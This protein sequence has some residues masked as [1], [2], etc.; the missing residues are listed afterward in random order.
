MIIAVVAAACQ[1]CPDCPKCPGEGADAGP[2][3]SGQADAG[4]VQTDAGVAAAGFGGEPQAVTSYDL[5]GRAGFDKV[6]IWERPDMES[7]RLGYM[8]RGQRTM[9]GDPRYA[10]ESCPQGWFAL[11][12]GGFVCQGRGMLV[13]TKPRYIHRP[14]P[15]PRVD[16][17]DPY[18][19]G[20]IRHDWTPLYKR[21]PT[22]EEIW[23]PPR[24]EDEAGGESDAGS[25]LAGQVRPP[26]DPKVEPGEEP[27]PPPE[28]AGEEEPQIPCADYRKHAK[29][30]YRAVRDF[31]SRG[32]WVAVSNRLRDDATAQYYYETIRGEYVPGGSVHLVRPPTYRGYEVLGET[33]LPAAIVSSR[34]AAFFQLRNGKFR[35]VGPADRLSVYR[36]FEESE[37]AGT[38]YYRI[39]G[40]RWLK[41]SQVEHFGIRPLPEGV[42]ENEKWIF[43]DLARQ[44]LEAYDGTTPVY[45]TLVSTGLAESEETV[46]PTG[47]FRINFKHVTDDMT[48]SVGDDEEVYSV[49]DVPWVQYLHM[50]VA[51]HASFWHSRYGTPKSHGCIN[52]SPADARFLFDWSDPP[53][54]SGWHAV[55]AVGGGPKT[56]VIIEGK[57]PK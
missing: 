2:R 17:L 46:T 40:D 34:N 4:L 38:K 36:V 39:E 32:F 11:P 12:G 8:R 55:A 54:P 18:P 20:F 33:P 6:N 44:T 42:G 13:G 48:G 19:H 43:I 10:S 5:H 26:C 56:T 31:L 45:V 51:L 3:A 25:P 24:V 14:P 9:L 28:A 22:A 53:L 23:S 52:L 21:I 7:T 57:T 16:E 41:D 35:G 1:E 15:L 50:N 37:T 27:A 47:R 29:R 30:N 49:S